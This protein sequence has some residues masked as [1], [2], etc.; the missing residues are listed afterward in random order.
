MVLL[1]HSILEL[2]FTQSIF[3]LATIIAA[4]GLIIIIYSRNRES[5]KSRLFIL[6]LLLVIGYLIS[7]AFHFL[8]MHSSDV[9]ILD[10]SCHSFL[11]LIIL[12]ITFFTWNFP[13]PQKLGIIRSLLLILPSILLLGFLWSGY[14]IEESSAH[15]TMF[16]V[17]YSSSYPIFLLW[18]AFLVALNFYW[19]LKR[20]YSER[21]AN[22]KKQILLL[23]LGL[24]I[25]N[26]ASFVF[27]MFLPWYLGFYYLV[28]ISPLSFLVGVILFT[29]V[30]VSRYD[31]FQA[32]MKRIHNFSIT[33]KIILSALILVPIIILLV[34]VPLIRFIFQ[35]E[36]NR[37][38]YR[39]FAISVFGGLIV[40]ISIAFVIVKIISN[41]LNKLKNNALEIEKGNY[42]TMIDFSSN[43]EF[44]DL[45]KAFNNMS[46]TLQNNSAELIKR[47]NRI[48]LLLNAFEESSTA[49]AIVDEGFRIIEA[50]PQ[51]SEI[52][53]KD[54]SEILNKS[55]VDVQF[56]DDFNEYFN[57]IKNELQLYSKFRG[58]LNYAEKFLLISVT[59]STTG[60]KFNGFLF[61]EV[62]ITEQK[63]LE[64]QLVKSEKLA[65]LGKMAAVLAHEIKTPLTSI[66]MN[67]DIIAEEL[68]L[69]ESEKEYLTIIQTEINRM[70]NLVKDVLQ[71]SRQMELD[72][73]LFD[74][75]DMIENIKSQLL[76]K[77][78]TKNISFINNLDKIELNADEHKLMQVFLN[79]IDNSIEAVS[80]NGK[81]ELTSSI[82][83]AL[84][85]IKILVIDNGMGIT[86]EAKIFE[87]FFTTKSSGTG[88]GLSVAQ[89]IIEQHKGTIRPLSSK[90]GKTVFEIILPIRQSENNSSKN[91]LQ[92]GMSFD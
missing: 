66:K 67:A 85:N 9:T 64:E 33:K 3:L 69:N 45:T 32:S 28:E 44:G 25:T 55:I 8:I 14:F 34:Q 6:I 65:A 92:K 52:V 72:Y 60:S 79:L 40:S 63:K 35:P 20:Y 38:L 58:E 51:F 73:S 11:L 39:F 4:L 26:L 61:I 23:F 2:D 76:N 87:P 83:E 48:S 75:F 53:E 56:K 18:Y 47:E 49:I 88:L 62:D 57:M 37:E 30:A 77:L 90:P 36:S 43:D 42:G 19:L 89:K 17:H 1:T 81:I 68:K 21:N 41:P 71:F 80:N 46:E 70:N 91:F 24:I 50:N 16:S 82:D 29:S 7:H 74:L 84:N 10:R 54:R 13:H 31:M 12:T 59:P 5:I 22:Q 86:E 15:H 27:G 78:K